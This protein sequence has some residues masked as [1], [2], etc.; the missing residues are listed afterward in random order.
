MEKLRKFSMIHVLT[1]LD[2]ILI[3]LIFIAEYP[4][5]KWQKQNLKYVSVKDI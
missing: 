4:K 3:Q 1:T 2:F 5:N